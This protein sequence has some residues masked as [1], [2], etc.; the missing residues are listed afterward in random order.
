MKRSL[1]CSTSSIRLKFQ[2]TTRDIVS[3]P[4]CFTILLA[5]N[6]CA[7]TQVRTEPTIQNLQ[8]LELLQNDIN[9]YL[10]NQDRQRITWGIAV[11]SMANNQ[12]LYAWNPTALLVPAST[13]KLVTLAVASATVG[14]DYRFETKLQTT[15]SINQG[16]LKGDLLFLSLIHI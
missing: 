4:L 3:L 5:F 6:G 2:R 7:K 12:Q 11:Q 8:A 14:W 13:M 9:S 1:R 16:V 10:H 15:G